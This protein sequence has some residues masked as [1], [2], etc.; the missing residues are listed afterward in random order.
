MQ[1]RSFA[2]LV[3]DAFAA[4]PIINLLAAADAVVLERVA[5]GGGRTVWYHCRGKHQL[6]TIEALLSPGSVVSFYFDG[7]IRNAPYSPELRSIIE[8]V[9]TETGDAVLGHLNKDGLHIDHE[10]VTGPNDLTEFASNFGP[11][12]RVFYGAFPNRDNDG[13]KAVTVTLPDHDG[14]VRPH[15]H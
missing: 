8:K 1:A 4:T 6:E 9:I 7:R 2:S 14:I 15:P 13:I 5:R 3:H 11:E 12:S 10:I